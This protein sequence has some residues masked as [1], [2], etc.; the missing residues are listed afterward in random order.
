MNKTTFI[1]KKKNDYNNI[2]RKKALNND[3]IMITLLCIINM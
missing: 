1:Q 3:A 2:K